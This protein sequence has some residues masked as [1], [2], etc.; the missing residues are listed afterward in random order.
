MGWAMTSRRLRVI[1]LEPDQA[2]LGVLRGLEETQLR[3]RM[4]ATR[5]Y[6]AA[7]VTFVTLRWWLGH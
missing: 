1:A 7:F 5:N 3:A 2:S 4:M 6:A